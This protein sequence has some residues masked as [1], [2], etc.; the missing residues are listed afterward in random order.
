[1]GSGKSTHGKKLA[2]IM[3]LPFT[4]LDL[5]IQKKENKTVQFIFDNE[6]EEQFRFLETKYLNELILEPQPMIVSLGGGTVC[7]NN[8]LELIKKNGVLIYIEMPAQAIAERLQKS[9]QKRPLL[10]KVSPDNLVNYIE[11][12]LIERTVFYKQS[13][14]IVNG[15]DLNYLQL[16]QLIVEFNKKNNV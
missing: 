13:H 16:Q 3:R 6:G 8:N 5:Y 12:K 1:M 15:L 10:Q 11:E 4:D 14:F 2:G 9:K 7:Y